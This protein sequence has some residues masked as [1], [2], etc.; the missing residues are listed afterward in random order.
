M[1][2]SEFINT[3]AFA[4]LSAMNGR[5]QYAY[6]EADLEKVYQKNCIFLP[7]IYCNDGF[8]ISVQVGHGHYCSSEN[9]YR[10]FGYNWLIAEWGYPSEIIDAKYNPEEENTNKTVGYCAVSLLDDLVEEHGGIDLMATL[11]KSY[12]E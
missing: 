8:S 2:V 11:S 3:F 12:E 5:G 6:M 4:T 1:K 7:R 10:T 9:G